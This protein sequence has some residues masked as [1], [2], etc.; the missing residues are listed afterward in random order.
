MKWHNKYIF[1]LFICHTFYTYGQISPGDLTTAHAKFEGMSNCTL[2]HDLGNKVTNNKCLNCHKNIQSLIK[3]NRGYHVSSEV[4]N[5]KCVKCHSEH[6]GRKFKMIRIDE[7]KFNHALTGYKL[8]GKHN[9]IDCK[10]CHNSKFI[11]NKKIKKRPNTFIGLD[12]KCITCHT[13]YHQ[14]TLS[15]N[16]CASCHNTKSFAPATNFD[17]NLADFKLTGK[18]LEVDCVKCHKEEKRNGKNFQNFNNISF[19][20]CNSCHNNPHNENINGSCKQCHTDQSFKLFKGRY[21]FNHDITNFILKGQHKKIDCFSC[22]KKSTNPKLVFQDKINITENNCVKCHQDKHKGKLGS[23]CAKCHNENSFISPKTLKFFNHKLTDYPLEGLH[24]KVDC[25]KCHKS[26]RYTR[27][28]NFL[29]CNNCHNDYHKGEFD[30]NGIATDCKT[31]HAVKEGFDLSLFNTEQ[32]QKTEF[33]LKGAHNATPCFACHKSEPRQKRWTFKNIGSKCVNCHQDIHKD[34]INTKFY[35]NQKCETCHSNDS[36]TDISFNHSKTDWPLTGKHLDTKCSKCHVKNNTKAKPFNQKFAKL[37]NKCSTCHTDKHNNQ[38]A[39]KGVTD[40]TRCHVTKSWIPEK[41][42]HNT[43]RFKLEG[44]HALLACNKCH[45][46]LNG[47]NKSSLNYKIK[48]FACIDC[49]Q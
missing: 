9:E 34:Y 43:T 7:K 1:L 30:K 24:K 12:T 3:K 29:H 22:H 2:C 47:N 35:P 33:P 36:W 49:H 40:C 44:K 26:G 42:D 13:D 32:H 20:N 10:K 27:P 21:R 28:I 38:F 11:T 18:H 45:K 37:N 31:C 48:K 19:K 39:I 6:Y 8:E 16:D 14:K 41:F 46:V 17:H 25:K 15:T 23:N 5:I 4:K